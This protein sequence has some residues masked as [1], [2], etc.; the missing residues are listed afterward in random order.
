VQLRK[1]QH[2]A[3]QLKARQTK[4]PPPLREETDSSED[5]KSAEEDEDKGDER[6]SEHD[7]DG[8]DISVHDDNDDDN[9]T[10]LAPEQTVSLFGS[11][12]VQVRRTPACETTGSSLFS[13]TSENAVEENVP[14]RHADQYRS[15]VQSF[16]YLFT[17][18]V[19]LHRFP[20]GLKIISLPLRCLHS[21]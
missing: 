18:N 21:Q 8:D 1:T 4:R 9:L 2:E 12:M 10:A 5:E 16:L 19:H 7:E 15:E 3:R 6:N 17:S 14:S 13:D 11:E 20:V